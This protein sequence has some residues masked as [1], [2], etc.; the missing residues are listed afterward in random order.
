M[1][2]PEEEKY[3]NTEKEINAMLVECVAGRAAE[4]IVFDTVT[5]GAANDIEKATRIA[6]AMV[7]Q[8][9]MSKRFGLVGLEVQ[10]NQYL[11]NRPVMNC[12]DSTAAEVDQEVI[13]ILGE[14]Y[15][16]A[17]RLLTEH[18]EALDKIAAFLIEKET[19]TGKEFMEI[20]HEVE[21]TSAS[22]KPQNTTRISERVAEPAAESVEIAAE[23]TSEASIAEASQ[24]VSEANAEETVAEAESVDHTTEN[25]PEASENGASEI[26]EEAS[27]DNT[28]DAASI[29]TDASEETTSQ[30]E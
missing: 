24:T 20:F 10:A 2:V 1:N 18:R 23:I 7:T 4:E 5:T 15:D 13:K 17:K 25:T 16:E 21:G 30:T 8:Y 28:A 6:R 22:D 26:T 19:I 3:L 14:A 12:S 11:D 9:G 27:E 29:E